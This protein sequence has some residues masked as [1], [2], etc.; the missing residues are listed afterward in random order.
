MLFKLELSSTSTEGLK[1][2]LK[3]AYNAEFGDEEESVEPQWAPPV[4]QIPVIP[5]P[6]TGP[7]TSMAQSMSQISTSLQTSEVDVTGAQWN[8]TIHT[9]GKQRKNADGSWK[10]RRGGP[11]LDVTVPQQSVPQVQ[12]VQYTAPI[13]DTPVHVAPPPPTVRVQSPPPFD[14]SSLT[15]RTQAVVAP[16]H[17]EV[18]TYNN[19]SVPPQIGQKPAHDFQSF[20][21]NLMQTIT[22][23]ITSGKL[24]Q[25]YVADLNKYFGFEHIHNALGNEKKC[26]ELFE[27]LCQQDFITR[28]G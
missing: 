9:S 26:M 24:Q 4:A 15:Q 12:P 28:V 6:T 1:T 8:P 23:L 11:E 13:L 14:V 20:K 16:T 22:N 17:V 7:V 2:L 21:D 25:T 18:P 5:Q 3:Q 10:K 19:I 27:V